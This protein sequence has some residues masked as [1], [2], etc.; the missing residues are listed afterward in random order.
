M[1]P[2]QFPRGCKPTVSKFEL[3]HSRLLTFAFPPNSPRVLM[4]HESRPAQTAMLK[5]SMSTHVPSG[6]EHLW[7]GLLLHPRPLVCVPTLA[8]RFAPCEVDNKD[9]LLIII[10][11]FKISFKLCPTWWCYSIIKSGIFLDIASFGDLKYY[12]AWF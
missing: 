1:G 11:N 2:K 12:C 9:I 7:Y 6:I 3:C 4:T 8:C 10:F 5:Y